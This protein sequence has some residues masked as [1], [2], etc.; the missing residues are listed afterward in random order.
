MPVSKKLAGVALRAVQR[1]DGWY[2]ALTGLGVA[3]MDKTA[4]TRMVATHAQSERYYEDVYHSDALARRIAELPVEEMFRQGFAIDFQ[5][6]Q[7]TQDEVRKAYDDLGCDVA[8]SWAMTLARVVGGAGLIVGAEDGQ[9][10]DMPLNLDALQRILWLRVVGRDR[11]RPRTFYPPS[12]PRFGEV[13][14]YNVQYIA[15]GGGAAVETLIV[16]ESRVIRC[17][18]VRVTDNRRAQNNG[19]GDSVFVATEE[20]LAKVG[21]S[22][23]A[24][25]HMLVD[26]SQGKFK[27][28]HL[29]EMIADEA[30]GD[31]MIDRRMR[32]IERARSIARAVVL[33]A[34]GEDFEYSE[35]SY[36]GVGESINSLMLYL[37]AVTGVP[38]SLLFGQAPAGLNATG[39]SD[40]RYFYDARKAEQTR[41]VKPKQ[42]RL[43]EL[44]MRAK[45]GP[46]SG[47]VPATWDVT[48]TPLW[49]LTELEQATLRKTT[50]EADS[51]DITNQVLLPEEVALSRYGGDKYSTRT[52]IDSG[53]RSP[54][55]EGA[56]EQSQGGASTGVGLGDDS[57]QEQVLN[58]AQVTSLVDVVKSVAT[59]ELP[60]SSGVQ[61]I[62]LSFGLTQQ[63]AEKVLANAGAGFTV[64][65]ET[66]RPTP[67]NGEALNT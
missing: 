36:A 10:A 1:M 39:D 51:I 19:W 34:D 54:K 55:E 14:S 53:L 16:H 42:K 21:S 9:S 62:M 25:G 20:A 23:Q 28:K 11:L 3:L 60:R 56:S 49:Q 38:V 64:A 65:V 2:N 37:S 61:I 26:G 40:I 30:D 46:T 50:S 7:E 15:I 31:Q 13:E 32:M 29:Q 33:D 44:V 27:L 35:R 58:G 6:G 41:E 22:F 59:G 52:V 24:I 67:S 8:L 47:A 66:T 5:E 12:H 57:V 43:L 4:S 45:Q 48:H 63:V 17:D 18:G